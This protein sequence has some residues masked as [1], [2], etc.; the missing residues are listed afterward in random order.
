MDP[1]QR[2]TGQHFLLRPL[3]LERIRALKGTPHY[4][5]RVAR[6]RKTA[7]KVVAEPL[8]AWDGDDDSNSWTTR[9][10][11][12]DLQNVAMLHLLTGDEKFAQ[13]CRRDVL[14]AVQVS[15]ASPSRIMA[16]DHIQEMYLNETILF[17]HEW[18]PGF[19]SEEERERIRQTCIRCMPHHAWE[20]ARSTVNQKLVQNHIHHDSTGMALV[21][22]YFNDFPD[23]QRWGRFAAETS[24][25]YVR[26]AFHGDGGQNEVATTY[27]A[28]CI[29]IALLMAHVLR[30]FDE[31]DPLRDPVF[32]GVMDRAVGWM[33]SL[34]RP[35]GGVVALND[36]REHVA[37]WMFR[38]G[39]SQFR[40]PHY[41]AIAEIVEQ[42]TGSANLL[43]DLLYYEPGVPAKLDPAARS[44]F[45]QSG[46]AAFRTGFGEKDDLLAQHAGTYI[47]GHAHRDRLG[48]EYWHAG[49]CLLDDPGG[50]KEDW[51]TF[52]GYYKE[53]SSHNVVAIHEPKEIR[54]EGR[55][56]EDSAFLAQHRGHLKSQGRILGT[57]DDAACAATVMQ[58]ETYKG[59]LQTRT[60]VWHKPSGA[61][62]VHDAVR[63]EKEETFDQLFHGMG[64]L[65]RSPA[66]FVFEDKDGALC[67]S[68]LAPTQPE[69]VAF[70]TPEH[71]RGAP[72]YAAV[73]VKAKQ[74]D[75]LTLLEPYS[76]AAPATRKLDAQGRLAVDLAGAKWALAFADGALEVRLDGRRI[77]PL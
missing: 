67:G 32:A 36:S 63:S 1:R 16:M 59:V 15:E 43:Y 2:P 74:V 41:Q 68:V 22:L 24:L 14:T 4:E 45:P 25:R 33:A 35:D 7:E 55:Y 31:R 17:I 44:V 42:R 76:G 20:M 50:F 37:A 12:I 57:F 13:A 62:L 39:A 19:F 70:E 73:R 77:V 49:K 51:P 72:E 6:T 9:P 46:T 23:A 26:D 60:L 29:H 8:K 52:V 10:R 71:A 38:F 61:L 47:G 75:F 69:L 48:F 27:H 34:V 30:D 53:T 64:A 58:A 56:K 40:N 28:C 65:K 66:R 18:L 54:F 11:F 21:A 3:D 5:D